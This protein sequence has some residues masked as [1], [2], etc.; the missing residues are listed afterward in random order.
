MI[1][2]HQK[3]CE[4]QNI[5]QYQKTMCW[6]YSMLQRSSSIGWK[7]ILASD[8]RKTHTFYGLKGSITPCFKSTPHYTGKVHSCAFRIWT[9]H[10]VYVY[11]VVE[12]RVRN[13]SAV[14]FLKMGHFVGYWLPSHWKCTVN[15]AYQNG[16]WSELVENGQWPSVISSTV[17]IYLTFI[18]TRTC[19]NSCEISSGTSI[20]VQ[21]NS[22][23]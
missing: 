18:I 6:Q 11:S 7:S 22:M 3:S 20:F 9:L 17:Y 16:F 12:I 8:W 5:M 23:T 21:D 2:R 19:S 4:A 10:F 13:W 15:L 1:F 14:F